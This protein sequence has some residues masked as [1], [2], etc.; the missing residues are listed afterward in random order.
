MTKAEYQKVDNI[1]SL[2]TDQNVGFLVKD[3]QLEN[4]DEE[5]GALVALG[6]AFK[7]AYPILKSLKVN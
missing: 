4:K 1:V 5:F 2:L 3:G 7:Q 6:Y